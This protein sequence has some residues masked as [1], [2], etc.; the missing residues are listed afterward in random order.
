MAIHD[1]DEDVDCHAPL[2]KTSVNVTSSR[3]GSP[4]A[5]DVAIHEDT[6]DVDCS[7]LIREDDIV[8]DYLTSQPRSRMTE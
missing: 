5:N 7:A 8:S 4:Q 6:T 2:A 1:V 3:G